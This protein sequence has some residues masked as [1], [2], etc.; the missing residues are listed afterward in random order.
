M[1]FEQT[2]CVCQCARHVPRVHEAIG[3]DDLDVE[4]DGTRALQP[5]LGTLERVMSI[6]GD[7]GP[8]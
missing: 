8:E 3:K 4:W 1:R 2:K 7:R 5:E 6:D